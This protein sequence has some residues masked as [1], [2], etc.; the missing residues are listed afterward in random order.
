MLR[1]SGAFFLARQSMDSMVAE[2]RPADRAS[3]RAAADYFKRSMAAVTQMLDEGRQP[4][5]SAE[6]ADAAPFA[7]DSVA[8]AYYVL[9]RGKAWRSLHGEQPVLSR[10]AS[11]RET[12][13]VEHFVCAHCFVPKCPCRQEVGVRLS[14]CGRCKAAS[15]CSKACQLAHWNAGHKNACNR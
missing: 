15:Y 10:G 6:M 4:P 3:V 5:T 1:G 11:A 2:A 7:R 9:L 13:I 12:C 14:K 8:F